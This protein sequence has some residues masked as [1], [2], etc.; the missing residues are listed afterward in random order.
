MNYSPS[1]LLDP[2][3]DLVRIYTSVLS[4]HSRQSK[5]FPNCYVRAVGSRRMEKSLGRSGRESLD[6]R[7]CS[8]APAGRLFAFSSEA[9]D[10]FPRVYK[11]LFFTQSMQRRRERERELGGRGKTFFLLASFGSVPTREN[12]CLHACMPARGGAV[13]PDIEDPITCRTCISCH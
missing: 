11:I 1:C 9:E 5:K 3:I 8:R 13:L 2:Q 7:S 4:R 12:F 10:F 6:R